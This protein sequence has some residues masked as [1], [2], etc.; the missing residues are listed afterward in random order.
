MKKIKDA[1]DISQ[2]IRS[3]WL[4]RKRRNSTDAAASKSA[5]QVKHF[6]GGLRSAK[7]GV[8]KMYSTACRRAPMGV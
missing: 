7:N 2:P 5:S 3:T 4:R 6:Q 8:R 1:C